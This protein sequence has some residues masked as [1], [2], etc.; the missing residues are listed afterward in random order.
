MLGQVA[1]QLPAL[2]VGHPADRALVGFV[3][4]VGQHVATNHLD[5]VRA[6]AT[7]KH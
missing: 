3:L 2:D 7:L 6:V 1:K 5:C 4:H